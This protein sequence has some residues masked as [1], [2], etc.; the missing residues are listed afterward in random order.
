MTRLF[1]LSFAKQFAY[2]SPACVRRRW[3]PSA[4]VS[5]AVLMLGA[6]AIAQQRPTYKAV[7]KLFINPAEPVL[8]DRA[9]PSTEAPLSPPT[10][11]KR[12]AIL[13][14]G[15]SLDPVAERLQSPDLM[16]Q[17]IVWLTLADAEGQP[18]TPAE[19]AALLSVTASAETGVWEIVFLSGNPALSVALVN[20][21]MDVYVQND[22]ANVRLS[23]SPDRVE[24]TVQIVKRAEVIN[25]AGRYLRTAVGL[26]VFL[27]SLGTFALMVIGLERSDRLVKT[28]A[29]LQR[30]YGCSVLELF[31]K[32][33]RGGPKTA[34]GIALRD[35]PSSL[36]SEIYR[37]LQAKLRRSQAQGSGPGIKTITLMGTTATESTAAAAANLAMSNAEA[38][39]KT[40]LIDG[41]FYNPSQTQLWEL[42]ANSAGLRQVF[43]GEGS[44]ADSLHKVH[45]HVWLLPLG[46]VGGSG[47][48][49][50][51]RSGGSFAEWLV[52]PK[53]QQL[54]IAATRTFDAVI[55]DAPPLLAGPEA[56]SLGQLSEGIVLFS[57]LGK[58]SSV[59][60]AAA[61]DALRKAE[62]TI[63]GL[64]VTNAKFQSLQG[65]SAKGLT[66]GSRLRGFRIPVW[67]RSLRHFVAS[68]RDGRGALLRPRSKS[69][70]KRKSNLKSKPKSKSTPFSTSSPQAEYSSA[71]FAKEEGSRSSHVI[72]IEAKSDLGFSDL[73]SEEI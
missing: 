17:V 33:S 9:A 5:M 61:N 24:T 15:N 22:L 53:M 23:G 37:S 27:V 8:R 69:E 51:S 1:P 28:V 39:K 38:Q 73:G 63:L 40:L 43:Q 30:L 50:G 54:L 7:G 31:P 48:R 55:I 16:Q 6:V 10:S 52:L 3:V 42:P 45:S 26:G 59:Q 19:V 34:T 62:Q 36:V 60:I 46:S 66:Q 11:S 64:V 44:L 72:Q 58:V 57:P 68:L 2:L 13:G 65:E 12:P 21:V 47:S 70:F 4:V 29:Q 41:N 20:A 18:P 25:R 14:S 49:S 56:L 67:A 71:D 32:D 35:A